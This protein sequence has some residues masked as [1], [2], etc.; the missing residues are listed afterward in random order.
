MVSV[1]FLIV[2]SKFWLNNKCFFSTSGPKKMGLAAW[3][4]CCCLARM[5]GPHRLLS[6]IALLLGG[7]SGLLS[8]WAALLGCSPRGL[9]SGVALMDSSSV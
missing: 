4:L 8:S 5:D 3:L 6:W 9:L 7:S 1:T 2:K